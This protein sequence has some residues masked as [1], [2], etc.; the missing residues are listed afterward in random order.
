M[1]KK[2]TIIFDLDE[3][4]CTKKKSNE[5]YANVLPIQP[6]INKLNDLYDQGYTI[7][8][9]TARNMVTQNNHVSKVVKNVGLVTM[10]WLEDHKVKYHGLQWGKE[11]GALYC[12]DKSCLNDPEEVQRR[13]DAINAGTEKWYLAEYMNLRNR[14]KQL[15]QEVEDLKQAAMWGKDE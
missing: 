4:L 5:T 6:M 8:I 1:E 7:I 11:F 9:S 3:T 2:P 10:Q 12:D 13:I 14:V 15:E